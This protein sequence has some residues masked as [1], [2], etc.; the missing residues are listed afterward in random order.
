MQCVYT[1]YASGKPGGYRIRAISKS[2]RLDYLLQQHAIRAVTLGARGPGSK[3][4]W[5]RDSRRPC[6]EY[7]L[8]L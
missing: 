7:E 2:V 1:L 4:G 8:G 6:G 5:L 3:S